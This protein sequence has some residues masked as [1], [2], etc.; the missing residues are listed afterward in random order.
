M[1]NDNVYMCILIN[2]G[3]IKWKIFETFRSVMIFVGAVWFMVVSVMLSMKDDGVES[4]L[5]ST[6]WLLLCLWMP[7]AGLLLFKDGLDKGEPPHS[8]LNVIFK[9]CVNLKG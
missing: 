7:V 8:T 3:Q 4:G 9:H 1:V 6:R 5:W 2:V